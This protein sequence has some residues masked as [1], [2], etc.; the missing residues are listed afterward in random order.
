MRNL[1]RLITEAERLQGIR[2][3]TV[4][5]GANIETTL[6]VA[7]SYEIASA[8]RRI[9]T[10]SGGTGYD[11]SMDMGVEMFVGF[12][13]FGYNRG[14]GALV[15]KA[16]GLEYTG[17]VYLPD[18]SGDVGDRDLTRQ[19]AEANRQAGV[20]AGGGLHPNT[21]EPQNVGL[22][23]TP[24]EVQEAQRILAYCAQL[25]EQGEVEGELDGRVVD[26]YAAARA[27]ELLE[28]SALCAHKDAHKARAQART[29]A[30]EAQ[31]RAQA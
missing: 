10:F 30:L 20:R 25:D 23:P 11:M 27:T 9:D 3:G 16:L 15:A 26:K 2:P 7:N 24:E 28:W 13:Q 8:S 5:I 22:T 12:D 31:E 4:R 19:R 18:T 17:S 29:R 1:D 21:V 6:G 14:E